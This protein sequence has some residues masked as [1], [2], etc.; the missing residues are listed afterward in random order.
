MASFLAQ[1][2]NGLASA[3][4]LFLIASG[5]SLIFGVTRVVNFA[6]GSL[7]MVGVYVAYS[8]AG[9]LGFWAAIA[10][11]AVAV[12]LL[13]GAIELAVLR[14]VY[15]RPELFQLLATF[16]VALVVKDACLSCGG[17]RTCSDRA[18][19][20]CATRSICSVRRCRATTCS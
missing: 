19:P 6:H 1:F 9:A 15:R 16:A 10:V 14:P 17:P 7:Y 13:G 20:A 4:T 12:A 18:R 5:L 11:A 2:L 3:S 8:A